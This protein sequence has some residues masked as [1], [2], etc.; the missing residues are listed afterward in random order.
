[1]VMENFFSVSQSKAKTLEKGNNNSAINRMSLQAFIHTHP[2]F[3]L[4]TS[5][6][7]VMPQGFVLYY[8]PCNSWNGSRP[9]SESFPVCS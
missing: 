8:F 1:M 2:K 9:A 7:R 4:F 3:K 6:I 5:F